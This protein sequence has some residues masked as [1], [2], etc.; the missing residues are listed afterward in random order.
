[1]RRPPLPKFKQTTK[2]DLNL[3]KSSR[4]IL[5]VL[6]V[7]MYRPNSFGQVTYDHDVDHGTLTLLSNDG[8]WR[9][10]ATE[11][12]IVGGWMS[13]STA[14]GAG[15]GP[16][17]SIW[18][19]IQGDGWSGNYGVYDTPISID[20]Y[21]NPASIRRTWDW[22]IYYVYGE[23]KVLEYGAFDYQY[24]PGTVA[25]SISYSAGVIPEP[26]SVG[27]VISALGGLLAFRRMSGRIV[28]HGQHA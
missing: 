9:R 19:R 26:S 5:L 25:Y 11:F 8:F 21:N 3:M 28:S 10:W 24:P 2:K 18:A 13:P 23:N 22:G 17:G 7:L 4:L 12:P 16:Y 6:A 20:Q 15:N 1:M 27:L 14:T